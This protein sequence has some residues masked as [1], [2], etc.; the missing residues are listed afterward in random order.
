MST[1]FEQYFNELEKSSQKDFNLVQKFDEKLALA[2]DLGDFVADYLIETDF[3]E[4]S[5]NVDHIY[6]DYGKCISFSKI[7]KKSDVN[8]EK[9]LHI[10]NL[11]VTGYYQNIN[12][13]DHIQIIR[14]V[15]ITNIFDNLI[16]DKGEKFFI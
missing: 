8:Y 15:F 9:F 10:Y 3:S 12:P 13:T 1:L 14:N 7:I 16:F 6:D 4:D 5:T 2:K 11:G